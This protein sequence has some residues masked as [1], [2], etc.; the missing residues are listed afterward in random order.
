[1]AE[2]FKRRGEIERWV[3]ELETL[4]KDSTDEEAANV[5]TALAG[6]FLQQRDLERARQY[7]EQAAA[8]HTRSGLLIA[9]AVYEVLQDWQASELLIEAAAKQD[10]VRRY[11]W[12]FWCKRTGWGNVNESSQLASAFMLDRQQGGDSEYFRWDIPGVYYLLNKELDNARRMFEDEFQRNHNPWSGLHAALIADMQSDSTRRKE[13]LAEIRT[14]ANSADRQQRS[15]LITLAQWM[16]D[17]LGRGGR[18]EFDWAAVDKLAATAA[19]LEQMHFYYFVAAYV[20]HHG[21]KV[22]ALEYWKRCMLLAPIN[23][24]TRSLA[25]AALLDRGSV[26]S[27]YK[28]AIQRPPQ[29]PRAKE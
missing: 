11:E 27:E 25:G 9:S 8:H 22:K 16:A 21:D 4:A 6:F 1:M 26:P 14:K 23:A 17:D 13:L 12:Y 20:D 19:S 15:Q 7:A 10:P 5:K 24:L 2:V 28:Q 3:S 18:A 29:R